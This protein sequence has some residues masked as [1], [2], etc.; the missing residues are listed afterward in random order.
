LGLTHR[1]LEH[2]HWD[3]AGFE[4]D[5]AF[6]IE[7]MGDGNVKGCE[8]VAGRGVSRH[9]AATC[10]AGR[11]KYLGLFFATKKIKNGN[12]RSKKKANVQKEFSHKK[13]KQTRK[14]K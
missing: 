3:F 2:I 1:S 13:R 7:G 12:V 6:A 14:T 8:Y 4:A 5:R 9:N 11:L 10:V